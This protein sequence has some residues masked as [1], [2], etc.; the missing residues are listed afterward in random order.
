[1][2]RGLLLSLIILI[3]LSACAVDPCTFDKTSPSCAVKQSESNATISAIDSDR[4][5]RSTQSAIYLSG[6]GTKAAVSSQATKQAVRAEATQSAM[7]ADA[8]RN[9]ISA[10][11]T[12][13]A[14]VYASTQT[15]VNGEATRQ[16]V[17]MG[18]V[19]DRAKAESA[20]VPYNAVFN[21]LFMWFILP[22]LVIAAFVFYGKRVV[23]RATEAA[24]QAMH[25]RAAQVTYGPENDPR[26]GFLLFDPKTGQPTKF[27]TADGLIGN[28]ADLLT[29]GTAVDKLDVPDQMKLLAFV[30]ASKRTTAAHISASTGTAPWTV[31]TEY[32]PVMAQAAPEALTPGYRINMVSPSM[33]PLPQWL[34]EVDRRLLE[35]RYD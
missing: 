30:E 35:A 24:T 21:I 18:G 33:P 9:A 7:K 27:I 8:T 28:F 22:G 3:L 16:A 12:Q 26:I 5:M 25:K 17:Q 20:A 29:G 31:T 1:M 13:D 23:K 4:E 11:S 6:E 34:D 14:V 19:I 15:F 10:A 2:K 32:A